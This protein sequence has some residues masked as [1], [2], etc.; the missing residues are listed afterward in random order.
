MHVRR[1]SESIHCKCNNRPSRPPLDVSRRDCFHSLP[2]SGHHLLGPVTAFFPFFLKTHGPVAHIGINMTKI[3]QD[4]PTGPQSSTQTE[5]YLTSWRLFIVIGTLFL[6]IFLFGL[7]VNIIGVA[8]PKITT[9]FGSL[10]KVAWYGSAYLL[11]VTAFQPGFG[12][13]YRFFNAKIVYLSSLFVF[14]G[15]T[16]IRPS[17]RLCCA[18]DLTSSVAFQWAPPFALQRPLP[19]SSFLAVLS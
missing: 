14:E 19:M 17:A 15:K 8:I 9:E 4:S 3:N 18:L 13:L 10:D 5:T 1:H 12:N 7:D 2:K 16:I 11:T 6:G